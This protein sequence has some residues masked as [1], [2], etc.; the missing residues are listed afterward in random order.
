MIESL[1]FIAIEDTEKDLDEIFDIL[2]NNDEITWQNMIYD[3]VSAE[4][5]DPWDVDVSLLSQRFLEKLK[6]YKSTLINSAVTGKI[7]VA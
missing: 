1:K 5:M 2:F 3:L 6:E 4:Q 7:K